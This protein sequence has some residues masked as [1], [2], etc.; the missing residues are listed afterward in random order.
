MN[1]KTER[2]NQLIEILKVR[3]F[4]SIKELALMLGVSEMTIRRDL[5]ILEQNRIA[6]NVYGTSVYNPAH[7]VS[8][9]DNE[10]N[11]FSEVEKQNIQKDSIGRFAASL[12]EQ[13]DIIIVDT[14]TTTERIVPYLPTNSDITVLCYNIN[15]LMELRRNPGVKMMFAGGHY[16]SNTQ[17]FECAEGIDFIRGLRAQKV[18]VSAAGV[19]AGLG[20]TCIENYEVPTKRAILKSSLERI[21]VADSSKFDVVRPA[22]FCDLSEINTIIT[23]S[24][25]S[26]EWKQR[27]TDMG[28]VLH[29][30]D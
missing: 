21:L 29:L 10:Y 9:N 26:E 27:I 1:K 17:M 2:I 14:G 15:I 5:K 8:K 11:L 20:V 13:G 6:E 25:L 30:C 7:T 16:H 12:V 28:I 4:V 18:F 24:G 22:Y 19:H 23:D 3:S